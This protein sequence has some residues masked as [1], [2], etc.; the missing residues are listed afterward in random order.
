MPYL[1]YGL[2]VLIFFIFLN[3]NIQVTFNAVYNSSD[4]QIKVQLMVFNRIHREQ[5]YPLGGMQFI[6]SQ[7]SA[8]RTSKNKSQSRVPIS[9]SIKMIS[10]L[11]KHLYIQE[12]KWHTI[13]GT[14]DAMYTALSFGSMW[15]LKGTLISLFT[16]L[17]TAK[18]VIVDI[19]PD[20]DNNRIYSD[21][22]CIFKLRIVHIM[23][24]AIHITWFKIRRY[25]NGYTA[26]GK[27]QPS[28]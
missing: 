4:G 22:H 25:L 17:S 27:P 23:L 16:C 10:I 28:H 15:A 14:G 2:I 20:F 11:C 24:I 13:I 18:T 12:F 7:L 5:S 1:Y 3:S 6:I 26:A 21:F 19:Q 8:P 9:Q